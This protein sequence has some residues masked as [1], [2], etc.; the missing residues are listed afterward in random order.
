MHKLRWVRRECCMEIWCDVAGVSMRKS[1]NQPKHTIY[2]S[3]VRIRHNI[4]FFSTPRSSNS[5]ECQILCYYRWIDVCST[6]NGTFKILHT[7]SLKSNKFMNSS[8]MN[9]LFKICFEWQLNETI[10]MLNVN[11]NIERKHIST[12]CRDVFIQM[13]E[14]AL[15]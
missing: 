5:L 15:T 7:F 9:W 2:F 1:F 8:F 3:I 11:C 12:K 10:K 4:I 14:R 13:N 6:W